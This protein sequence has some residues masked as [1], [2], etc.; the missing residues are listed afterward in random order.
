MPRDVGDHRESATSYW[1]LVWPGDG[2]VVTRVR[3]SHFT[4]DIQPGYPRLKHLK[5]W[6]KDGYAQ[7]CRPG[8]I[9][10][11]LLTPSSYWATFECQRLWTFD[12]IL[13]TPC[14]NSASARELEPHRLQMQL[15]KAPV[16]FNIREKIHSQ[17]FWR[18]GPRADTRDPPADWGYDGTYRLCAA[19][20][21]DNRPPPRKQREGLSIL[22]TYFLLKE[23][24][25][26]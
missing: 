25:P 6:S 13:K 16:V 3:E 7:G 4:C 5:L 22:F 8:I 10:H 15:Y 23:R 12:K 24:T 17:I 11:T 1:L 20:C 26:P 19:G 14:S 18:P 9:W 21:P 2:N